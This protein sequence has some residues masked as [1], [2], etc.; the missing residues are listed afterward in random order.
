MDAIG[1]NCVIQRAREDKAWRSQLL[2]G[3]WKVQVHWVD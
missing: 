1:L 3:T 2:V